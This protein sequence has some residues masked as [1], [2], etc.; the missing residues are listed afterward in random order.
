[1]SLAIA[2]CLVSSDLVARDLTFDER[3]LAQ[4]AIERVYAAHQL[5]ESRPLEELYPQATLERR[6]R[7]SLAR[8][9][10]LERFWSTPITGAMLREESA[11]IARQTRLPERLL[12]IEAALGGDSFLFEETV[13]RATLTDRL[14]RSFYAQDATLHAAARA[15]ADALHARLV[16]GALSP[17]TAE[18]HRTVLLARLAPQE[19]AADLRAVDGEIRLAPEAFTRL[20]DVSPSRPGEVGPVVENQDSFSFSVLLDGARDRVRLATYTVAKRPFD[21]W[22]ATVEPSLDAASVAAVAQPGEPLPALSAACAEDT[23]DAG[24]LSDLPDGRMKATAVWT[25]TEM[26]VW[27]GTDYTTSAYTSSGGRYDPLTDS[28]SSVSTLNAP[29]GRVDHTAVWTGSRMIVWGGGRGGP[30]YNDGG[31]YDPVADSWSPISLVNAPTPRQYHVAVW[32]GS[33]MIVW[34]GLDPNPPI[35]GGGFQKSG[36]I[37][38]PG[39]DSWMATT[40]PAALA[41][42][43]W[44][45]A[46]WTGSRMIVWGGGSWVGN[47]SGGFTYTFQSDGG[48]F[49]PTNNSWQ[50]LP[51][52]NAPTPRW[53]HTAVWTGTQLL[54]WGGEN[55]TTGVPVEG[56]RYDGGTNTWSPMSTSN[57]PTPRAR[58]VAVWAGSRMIVWGGGEWNTTPGTGGRYD[59]ATDTWSPTAIIG[60]PQSRW[61]AVAVSTGARMVVWGGAGPSAINNAIALNNGGRYD[62]AS[63]TWTATSMGAVPQGR[64]GHTAVWTGNE[65]IVWGGSV[66]APNGFPTTTNTGGRYDAALDHWMPTTTANAPTARDSHAAVWSGQSMIVWGGNTGGGRY[67][68][69]A[70]SWQPVSLTGAP[71]STA[72]P[73]AFWTGS[74]MLVWGGSAGGS[75][76]GASGLYD[77]KAD[78]WSPIAPSPV[79]LR[80]PTVVWTGREM[81]VWGGR[82]NFPHWFN[83]GYRYNLA[84]NTWQATTLV[85]APSAREGASGIW[86]GHDLIVWGG[87]ANSAFVGTGGRY[88]PVT[89]SWSPIA[90]NGAPPATTGHPAAWTGAE[91]LIWGG[92]A[93]GGMVNTGGRYDPTADSWLWTTLENAPIPRQGHSATWTPLQLLVWGGATRYESLSTGSRYC[94][95]PGGTTT[96]Y[97]DLDGDGH[98][99]AAMPIYACAVPAASA[100][101]GDDCSDADA[102]SWAAP[103]EVPQLDF[104]DQTTLGWLAPADPG[105]A[106]IGYDLLRSPNP[107]DFVSSGSCLPV[108]PGA[109]SAIDPDTPPPN[110]FFFYLVRAKNACPAGLGSLGSGSNGTPRAGKFCP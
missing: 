100:P 40:L 49:N 59:P 43:A 9:A 57:Q 74:R 76:S 47:G 84:A 19:D 66:P 109:T 30:Q 64:S 14:I 87:T 12:E 77:P 31:R 91:M 103:S 96:V 3:V 86:T 60:A 90:A 37:Y 68:P 89:D 75:L 94:A 25:G 15:E 69:L 39:T 72:G 22:W 1:V 105:A 99:D 33:R 48:L 107:G 61:D 93:S 63:D 27:G 18:G 67:D 70:D 21:S 81:L 88:D 65:L 17:V 82:D 5:G 101:I 24:G 54:V 58:H 104:T 62:P 34:G 106:V 78:T 79:A 52:L 56:G 50:T 38:D 2:C 83:A 4:A 73:A 80:G 85:N 35:S 42:R 44:A 92:S 29:V 6:V 97:Q 98:G 51:T 16:S 13:A 55:Y 71:A 32:T 102:T 41:G 46:A 95:C 11:R 10:A 36:A 110:G 23:W 53:R 45:T 7:L 20:R 108:A 8:S 28:W 26:I